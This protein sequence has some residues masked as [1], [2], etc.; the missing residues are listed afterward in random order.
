MNER[1]SDPITD[2]QIMSLKSAF[3]E[4][5]GMTD[6]AHVYIA[7]GFLDRDVK[8]LEDIQRH[9]WYFLRGKF[10]PNFRNEDWTLDSEVKKTIADLLSEYRENI[11]GQ[12]RMF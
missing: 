7:N 9:E 6:K 5:K 11:T 8:R 4:V 3:R 1:T 10:Y 12:L 2:G